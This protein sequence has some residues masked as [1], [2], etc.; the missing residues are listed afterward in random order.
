MLALALSA[1]IVLFQP[2]SAQPRFDPKL[3][4]QWVSLWNSYDLSL[5]DKLF[6]ADSRVTYFSSEK[7]G[8]IRGIEAVRRH[9][10]SFGF[11]PDGKAQASK[12]WLEEVRT[13]TFPG[14]AIVSAT[15]HFRR[16]GQEAIQRG[17]VTLLYVPVAGEYRI[18]HAH[19]SSDRP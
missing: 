7:K 18:A 8:L 9:H 2:R 10:E 19:F 1:V 14:L 13:E 6:L 16:A 11:V 3:V 17:P 12:L 15:W 5:V 4:D